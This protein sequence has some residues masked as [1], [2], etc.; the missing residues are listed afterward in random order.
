VRDA[1]GPVPVQRCVRR[2]ERNLLEHLPERDHPRSSA[3]CVGARR[4]RRALERLRG[5]ATGLD[6]SHPGVA[7]SLREGLVETLTVTRLGVHG[8][9]RRTLQSTHPGE[10]MIETVRRTSRNVKHWQSG[11]MCQRRRAAGRLEAKRQFRR[12]MGHTDLA[13]LAVALERDVPAPAPQPALTPRRCR[14]RSPQR[15][16]P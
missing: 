4:P 12:I 9:L 11:E 15:S 3:G 10:S 5:L 13:K 2:K 7:A 6:R 8:A 1:L 14:P 16:P